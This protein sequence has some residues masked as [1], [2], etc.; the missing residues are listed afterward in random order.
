MTRELTLINPATEEAINTSEI[1]TL[2]RQGG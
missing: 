2:P 1:M